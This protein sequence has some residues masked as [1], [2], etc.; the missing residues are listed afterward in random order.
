M[1]LGGL[2]C[3]GPAEHGRDDV[4]E[5]VLSVKRSEPFGENDGNSGGDDV[6]H[7]VNRRQHTGGEQY[8]VDRGIVASMV[9]TASPRNASAGVPTIST[10][11]T[12]PSF[13]GE[14][15]QART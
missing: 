2:G 14:R 3:V 6:N 8:L 5:A 13:T 15:F 9:S 10:P 12:A 4:G 11:G 1:K 7:R